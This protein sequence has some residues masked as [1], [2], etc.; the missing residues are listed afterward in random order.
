MGAYKEESLSIPAVIMELSS[1]VGI[2]LTVF[3]KNDELCCGMPFSS[4]GYHEASRTLLLKTLKILYEKSEEGRLPV[5]VDI[6][7][8]TYTFL[9][10]N[11]EECKHIASKLI[12]VD[13][14]AFAAEYLISRWKQPVKKKD[15]VVL[16]PACSVR[17]MKLTEQLIKVAAFC[18]NNVIVPDHAGC[19]GMAGDRGLMIPEL[20]AS[21]QQ[22]ESCEVQKINACGHY[23]SSR[24]CE[25]SLT[26][27]SGRSYESI[28]YLLYHTLKDASSK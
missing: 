24:T 25:Y 12:F 7:P 10:P 28:L 26:L 8:C 17:K 23:S 5:L 3:K 13:V 11:D 15:R 6:S 22:R 14:V 4:K 16:H 19:C 20:T 1:M 2:H 21:A 9:H 18:A 27:Q